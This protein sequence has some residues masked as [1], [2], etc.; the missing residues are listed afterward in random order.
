MFSSAVRAGEKKGNLPFSM[1]GELEGW[2]GQG[3][4]SLLD[5]S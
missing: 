1:K 2:Q 5:V 4:L 3:V